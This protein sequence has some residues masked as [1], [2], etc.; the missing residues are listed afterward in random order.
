MR[1]FSTTGK[2]SR[3][4]HVG[5]DL[6]PSGGGF[7]TRKPLQEFLD[8]AVASRAGWFQVAACLTYILVRN[9][10]VVVRIST[11]SQFPTSG[12]LENENALVGKIARV[13]V[14]MKRTLYG[15]LW[16]LGVERGLYATESGKRL[17][18]KLA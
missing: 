3:K 8:R 2:R 7:T 16:V 1:G 11:S 15:G 5:S 10:G 14:V 9:S 13:L 17:R 6:V 12:G 18:V 4:G